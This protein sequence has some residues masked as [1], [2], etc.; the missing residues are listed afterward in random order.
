MAPVSRRAVLALGA[1]ICCPIAT[2]AASIEPILRNPGV[3]IADLHVTWAE[4]AEPLWPTV[5]EALSS[6]VHSILM[7]EV[8]KANVSTLVGR[9]P[10][11][12]EDDP[13]AHSPLYVRITM[14]LEAAPD[15]GQTI[16]AVSLKF[17]RLGFEPV[18]FAQPPI[19]FVTTSSDLLSRA[20]NA[21]RDQLAEFVGVL[22]TYENR[23]PT[24]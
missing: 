13:Y 17:E 8:G 10:L 7:D 20:T 11:P 24:L 16:G 19:V 15:G 5:A 3:L 1:A 4:E 21:L 2:V 23:S 12:L 6:R 22:A 18:N 14:K 9:R